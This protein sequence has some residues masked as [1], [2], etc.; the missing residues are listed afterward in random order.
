VQRIS[1]TF[2]RLLNNVTKNSNATSSNL[3][4]HR[5]ARRRCCCCCC[6]GGGGRR[7]DRAGVRDDV[8]DFRC[9]ARLWQLRWRSKVVAKQIES[10]TF[11]FFRRTTM[12]ITTDECN[13]QRDSHTT[14]AF[15]DFFF[16]GAL[17]LHLRCGCVRSGHTRKRLT[18]NANDIETYL[19]EH[20]TQTQSITLRRSDCGRLS[21]CKRRDY[22]KN[23]N[24]AI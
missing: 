8:C 4:R 5:C 21:S 15:F 14:V 24:I 19:S 10:V 9:N 7:C 6:G 20:K 23:T 11:F 3:Y 17:F 18:S 1:L 22:N 16:F 13:V 12:M 2:R